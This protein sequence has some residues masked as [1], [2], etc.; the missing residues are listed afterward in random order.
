MV[1]QEQPMEAT[2][3]IENFFLLEDTGLQSPV[4]N[5]QDSFHGLMTQ[6]P[7]EELE[8]DDFPQ[9]QGLENRSPPKLRVDFTT[10]QA[11]KRSA[12]SELSSSPGNDTTK[13]RATADAPYPKRTARTSTRNPKQVPS[14]SSSGP[15]AGFKAP[16]KKL[17]RVGRPVVG[18]DNLNY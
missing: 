11:R 18:L 16:P 12:Q 9:M 17:K 10:A 13:N 15:V 4:Q 6:H 7:G 2:G 3:E 8:L 1:E 5:S 14:G